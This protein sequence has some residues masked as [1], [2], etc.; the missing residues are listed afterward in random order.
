MEQ[1]LNE[2]WVEIIDGE[3]FPWHD[4]VRWLPIPP[5]PEEKNE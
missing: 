3:R 5:P 4:V 2:Q 1:K